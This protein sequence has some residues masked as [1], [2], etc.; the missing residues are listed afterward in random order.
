[1]KKCAKCNIE[2]LYINFNIN[3]KN[4][5]DGKSPWC[6]DCCKIYNKEYRTKRLENKKQFFVSE[7]QCTKCLI[8]KNSKFFY[9]KS[10]SSDGLNSACKGCCNQYR[11]INKEKIKKQRSEYGKNNRSKIIIR[12]TKY[13]KENLEK[14]K[15]MRLNRRQFRLKHDLG[16]KLKHDCQCR[17]NS[18]LRNNIKS[19]RTMNLVGSSILHLKQYL[20]SKF[21]K[22]MTWENRGL[23]GWHIDHII[24]VSSFD[25]SDPTQQAKCFHYTNLQ[26]L[27]ATTEIAVQNGENFDYI[28]NLEKSDKITS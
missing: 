12:E 4:K 25:L 8:T 23:F 17:I 2:K 10:F 26:P 14:V 16:F 24:P 6:K 22:G 27:W 3:K 13:R 21:T 28:G 1:M 7:K 15:S 20:E 5:T 18:S 19:N 11:E 9:K